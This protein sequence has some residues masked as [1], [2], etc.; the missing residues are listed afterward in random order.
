MIWEDSTMRQLGP[1]AFLLSLP[2]ATLVPAHGMAAVSSDD[3]LARTTGQLVALCSAPPTDPLATSAVNFC[4]GFAVAVARVLEEE[5][6]ANP[7]TRPMFC[8]PA[9]GVSRNQAVSQFVQW[10][11]A[12]PS[13]MSMPATD[14]VAGF[15]AANYPCSRQ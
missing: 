1:F 11:S 7:G 13:R 2:F 10:A 9:N 12:D 5:D 6:A 14:G 8:L 3:F 15:L 4:H